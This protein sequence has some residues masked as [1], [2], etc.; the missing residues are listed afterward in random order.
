MK[1]WQDYS[2]PEKAMLITIGILIVLIL[3]SSTRI[4]RG[5]REGFG[6]FF[7]VCDTTAQTAPKN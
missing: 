5:I 7:S 3:F 6:H 1:K 2:K 4:S